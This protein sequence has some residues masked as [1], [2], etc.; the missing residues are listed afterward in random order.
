MRDYYGDSLDI[1]FPEFPNHF[2]LFPMVFP[3]VSLSV[4][5]IFS[6][7][8]T[9]SP[10]CFPGFHFRFCGIEIGMFIRNLNKKML[11]VNQW[12]SYR[13]EMNLIIRNVDKKLLLQLLR[14]AETLHINILRLYLSFWFAIVKS[15]FAV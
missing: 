8:P 11:F 12:S 2:L 15:F 4:S 5:T 1:M 9:V 10:P 13:I 14:I 6:G 3:L 7:V